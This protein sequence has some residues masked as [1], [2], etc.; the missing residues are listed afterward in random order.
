VY[1][2]D[3]ELMDLTERAIDSMLK[4][5]FALTDIVVLTGKGKV[6]SKLLNVDH[7]GKYSTRHFTGQYT[8]D[9]EQRWSEGDL[10]TDSIYRFK[11]QCAPAIIL[12]EIDFTDMSNPE[13]NK[14][15]T[16]LTRAQ[17]AVDIVMSPNAEAW[18]IENLN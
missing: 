9:G 7:V 1:H 3:E 11:G 10:L 14:L 2:N 13:R 18:F 8:V 16:G 4:R 12:T 15:F 5:G 6:K 17:M